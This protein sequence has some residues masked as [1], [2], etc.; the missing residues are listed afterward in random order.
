[1]MKMAAFLLSTAALSVSLI[2]LPTQ[3]QVRAE[4]PALYE[5]VESLAV[6]ASIPMPKLYILPV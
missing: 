4:A 2:P 1:M 5:A 3:A 6:K